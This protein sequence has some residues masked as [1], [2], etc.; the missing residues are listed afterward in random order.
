MSPRPTID[1]VHGALRRLARPASADA[2]LE[3]LLIDLW[4]QPGADAWTTRSVTVTLQADDGATV[5]KVGYTRTG[6]GAK[7]AGRAV[8]LYAL[9]PDSERWEVTALERAAQRCGGE[10]AKQ[11]L[12]I[13]D[14]LTGVPPR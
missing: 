3:R 7:L 9:V 2:I 6:P 5:R 4:E 8:P 13:R 10:L 1:Q 11:L 14:T 12:R